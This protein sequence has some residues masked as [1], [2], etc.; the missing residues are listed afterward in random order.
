MTK[1]V[2]KGPSK[3]KKKPTAE[4]P[5]KHTLKV[6]VK[7][8]KTSHESEKHRAESTIR[9]PHVLERTEPIGDHKGLPRESA[10]SAKE[11]ERVD[12]PKDLLLTRLMRSRKSGELVAVSVH[13][14]DDTERLYVSLGVPKGP[15]GKVTAE[16]RR[17]VLEVANHLLE[18][19][20]PH[21]SGEDPDTD[22]PHYTIRT[23]YQA[24]ENDPRLPAVLG[25]LVEKTSRKGSLEVGE[26]ETALEAEIGIEGEAE[27]PLQAEGDQVLAEGRVDLDSKP[28]DSEYAIPGP[29]DDAVSSVPVEPVA[30]DAL[31]LS[32]TRRRALPVFTSSGVTDAEVKKMRLTPGLMCSNCAIGTECPEYN[33]GYVCAYES[34]FSAFPSRDQTMVLAAMRAIVDKNKTRLLRSYHYEEAVNGGQL[35]MNV[36]RQS[37]VVIEQLNTLLELE[38]ESVR[39]DLEVRE[40]GGEQKGP[41]ILSR[42]FGGV[43][44]PSTVRA[45]TPG[46]V[47]IQAVPPTPKET[48]RRIIP[49]RP[50]PEKRGETDTGKTFGERD[51]EEDLDLS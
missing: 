21:P 9:P 34:A 18:A 23:R 27:S 43:Q 38:R 29:P 28:S 49:T 26:G 22:L 15:I 10:P 14:Y 20:G 42:L 30:G 45:L 50:L 41:G 35:D 33:P 5:P 44:A 4:A 7:R 8:P 19:E 51:I 1:E 12:I 6:I 25:S 17:Q 24:V 32:V 48:V 2:K 3:G 36:T 11:W 16:Q 37:T 47:P 31:K 39:A 13:P 40:G 46:P